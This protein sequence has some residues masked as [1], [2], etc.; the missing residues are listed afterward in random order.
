LF[1]GTLIFVG[2][3]HHAARTNNSEK[4]RTAVLGQYLP[5]FVRPMED[6]D[7]DLRDEWTPILGEEKI[8]RMEKTEAMERPEEIKKTGSEGIIK[9]SEEATDN[10]KSIDNNNDDKND[11]N[12]DD[13]NPESSPYRIET[14]HGVEFRVREHPVRRRATLRMRQL[15]GMKQLY[16]QSFENPGRRRWE[17]VLL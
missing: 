1:K 2:L 14:F 6:V 15:L 16:P 11:D 9:K 5:K 8:I 17:G 7:S 3:L 4:S 13:K 12:N 10:T